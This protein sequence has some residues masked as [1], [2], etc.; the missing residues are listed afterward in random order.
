MASNRATTDRGRSVELL[1]LHTLSATRA[2]VMRE[3]IENDVQVIAKFS[4][5]D[6]VLFAYGKSVDSSVKWPE[7]KPFFTDHAKWCRRSTHFTNLS[8][9]AN[10]IHELQFMHLDCGST[11]NAR[12]I[13]SDPSGDRCFETSNTNCVRSIE[14]ILFCVFDYAF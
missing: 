14:S 13:L 8:P 10:V 6:F 12:A 9:V 7:F 3:L 11:T 4:T 5:G 1:A 2:V